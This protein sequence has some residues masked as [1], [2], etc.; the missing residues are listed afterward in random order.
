MQDLLRELRLFGLLTRCAFETVK[1]CFRAVLDRRD[2]VPG[3]AAAIQCFGSQVQ[4]SP[5]VHSLVSAGLLLRGGEFVLMAPY[6]E[7]IER[8]LTETWRRLVLDA[9]VE[10][11]CLTKGFRE[12]LLRWGHGGGFSVYDRHLILNAEGEPGHCTGTPK[13]N[14]A[15]APAPHHERQLGLVQ[16][17]TRSDGNLM[18]AGTALIQT[19]G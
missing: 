16:R 13:A 6:D 15:I 12:E 2:G 5:H 19:A 11:D 18:S 3:M 9:L 10:E 17:S 4:W 14:R 8:L 7:E 1:R